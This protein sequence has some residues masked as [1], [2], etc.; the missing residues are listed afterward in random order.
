MACKILL[1]EDNE[2]DIEL[3]LHSFKSSSVLNDITIA[4]DSDT[5]WDMLV[6]EGDYKDSEMPDIVLLDINLP[7]KEGHAL[8]E[9]IKKD[10]RLRK[11]IVIMLTNSESEIDIKRALTNKADGYMLKPANMVNLVETV[12]CINGLGVQIIR[13]RPV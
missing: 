11:V 10:M 1:V 12:S 9:E 7:G 8:L 6:Q 2:A 3:A 5:A 13:N 4:H